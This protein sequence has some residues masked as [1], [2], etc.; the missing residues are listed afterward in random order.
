MAVPNADDLAD[1]LMKMASGEITLDDEPAG[2]AFG[3]ALIEAAPGAAPAPP[4]PQEIARPARPAAPVRRPASA[5]EVLS[6]PPMP[7]FPVEGQA[8]AVAEPAAR[9]MVDGIDTTAGSLAPEED[10]A[11]LAR[12]GDVFQPG[13]YASHRPVRQPVYRSDEFRRTLIPVLG[14]SGVLLIVLAGSCYVVRP[15]SPLTGLPP[16]MPPILFIAGG[17]LLALAVLNMLSV[18]ASQIARGAR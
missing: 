14:V 7:A 4:Q 18:R 10:L 5:P 15:E 11:A 13:G 6:P 9:P 2:S 3:E 12:A 8:T 1:A 17:V 16:W